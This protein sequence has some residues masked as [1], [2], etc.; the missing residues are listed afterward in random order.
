MS[1]SP[2]TTDDPGPDCAICY[3]HI[4]LLVTMILSTGM[5]VRW[6]MNPNYGFDE[7]WHAAIAYISPLWIAL[8]TAAADVHPFLYYLL[9]RPL[10]LID[11]HPFALRLL[12]IVPALL[13]IPLLFALLHRLRIATPIALTTIVI[14][15]A[16]FSFN[17]MGVIVRSYALTT[18]LLLGALWFWIDMLPGA[19]GRPSR[20]SAVSSLALATTAF[21]CLY[22]A[23]LSS[24]ALAAATVIMMVLNRRFG[25]QL[26]R[27]WRQYS[28]WPEWSLFFAAHAAGV[29]WFLRGRFH[30]R[31]LDSSVGHVTQWFAHEG[32][33]PFDYLLTNLRH[34]LELFTPLMGMPT[35]MT[36][37]ALVALL[38]LIIGL[39]WAYRRRGD[40]T[41]AILVLAPLLLTTI[42]AT[43][44]LWGIYPFGGDLR[45]Q[46]LLF[47][48][49]LLLVPLSMHLLWPH[50]AG[51]WPRR[52][53][54]ALVVVVAFHT[55]FRTHQ[56]NVHIGDPAPDRWWTEETITLFSVSSD[57]PVL[58]SRYNFYPILI[59]LLTPGSR[60]RTSWTCDTNT[61]ETAPQGM[62]AILNDWPEFQ[63][64]RVWLADSGT[65]DI[66][67]SREWLISVHP[68]DDF[69][70][71]LLGLMTAADITEIRILST[72]SSDVVVNQAAL[73]A[74]AR[75]NGFEL[76]GFHRSDNALIWQLAVAGRQAHAGPT[77]PSGTEI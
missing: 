19:P 16:S 69:F 41:L 38:I 23:V 56:T 6:G 63:Q 5:L 30:E 22:A 39:T 24:A 28:G 11:D 62:R 44:G 37:I 25:H 77:E 67:K 70:G 66:F 53:A 18:L 73:R 75:R 55:S 10:H 3:P 4:V 52:L 20:F 2:A 26:W 43:L 31:D 51:R 64:H 46:Y 49:L 40:T 13:T 61:C 7:S 32:Q 33:R 57:I 17:E 50:L 12:S 21:W 76:T 72:A 15:A 48:F 34:E 74:T 9:L 68:D 1:R 14:L 54:V 71:R 60:F 35:G 45:H 47:P 42:L 29:G 59:N 65:T 8:Q 58:L 27:N 36:N